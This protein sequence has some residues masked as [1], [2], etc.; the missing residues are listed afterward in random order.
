[1]L[2]TSQTVFLGVVVNPKTAEPV[3]VTRRMEKQRTVDIWIVTEAETS[4]ERYYVDIGSGYLNENDGSEYAAAS[5]LTGFP[6]AHTPEGVK[7]Y[8]GEGYGTCLYTALVLLATASHEKELF[9]GN[10]SGEGQAICSDIDTRSPSATR[11]WRKAL[12]LGLTYQET[13]QAESDEEHEEEKTIE[14][15]DL[16]NYMNR[17][18]RQRAVNAIVAEVENFG[19]WSVRDIQMRGTVF[20][21]VTTGYGVRELLADVFTYESAVKHHLVAVADVEIGTPPAWAKMTSEVSEAFKNTILALNVANQETRMVGR[22]AHIARQAG[23]TEREITAMLMRNRF[24]VDVAKRRAPSILHWEDPSPVTAR[25]RSLPPREETESSADVRDRALDMM[26]RAGTARNPGGPI[27]FARNPDISP[28]RAERAMVERDL[29][30]LEERRENLWG[31][32]KLE[33][34]P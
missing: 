24:G 21:T 30:E 13:G 34:L 19:S 4:K 27:P 9:V 7:G 6:R 10:M 18:G 33:E 22:L 2:R 16:E 14:D 25:P 12:E 5:D 15:E 26:A 28:T 17:T 31:H 8:Q 29:A 1:M 20:K 11:W 32:L 3:F 23:A